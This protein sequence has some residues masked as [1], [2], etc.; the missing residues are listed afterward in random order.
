MPTGRVG[1][2]VDEKQGGHVDNLEFVIPFLSKPDGLRVAK[3]SPDWLFFNTYNIFLILPP[4]G[5]GT[6]YVG[7]F[8]NSLL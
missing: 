1:S 2:M 5:R 3:R 6:L 7:I 4:Q 8:P